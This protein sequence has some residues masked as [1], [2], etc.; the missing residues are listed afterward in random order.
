MDNTT[1]GLILITNTVHPYNLHNVSI[2]SLPCGGTYHFHYERS[3]FHLDA[4]GI[5]ALQGMMGLLVLRDFERATF[6]PLR[7][8]RVLTVDNCGGLV[9]L[10]LEFLHF[11]EY[12]ASRSE[13]EAGMSGKDADELLVEREKYSQA[14]AVQVLASGCENNQKQHLEK[15][16]LGVNPSELTRIRTRAAS[17]GPEFA[18]AWLHVVTV[19]GSLS[20]YS[21]VCFYLVSSLI[22]LNSGRSASRFRN[23]WQ[24]G[25][26]LETGK[27]Y[28]IRIYQVIGDRGLPPKPGYSIRISYM[29]GH[30]SLLCSEM[31][32]DGAYDRMSVLASVLPN[33]REKSHS[34]MLLTCNQLVADPADNTKSSP[35]P[36]TP[37][38]LRIQW[39]LWDRIMKRVG[40]PALLLVGAALF[41]T[42]DRIQMRMGLGDS[43]KYVIQLLGLSLLA[44]GGKNWGFLTG[45]FKPGPP[46]SRA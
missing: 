3:Y 18:H 8:F 27:V 11:V 19:L 46:G 29:Q 43:G 16:I 41:V 20:V 5:E 26:V 9:F 23:P 4:D 14:I 31:P 30:L 13:I 15:L 17:D 44:L 32:V 1:P 39:P 40:Y 37:L 34:E 35:L 6:I 12:E 25:L 22:E 21:R 28:L 24:A 10:D 38:Q 7:T 36:A 42:S 45:A 33:E 2:L